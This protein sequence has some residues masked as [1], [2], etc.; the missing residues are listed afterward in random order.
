M[1]AALFRILHKEKMDRLAG[2]PGPTPRFPFGTSL[3]F[4]SKQWPWEVCAKYADEYGPMT[5]IWL[6]GR[7]AVVLNS[8]ELIGEV[9]ADQ[10]LRFYKKDPVAALRPVITPKSL[11]ISNPPQWVHARESNPLSRIDVGRWL[12]ETLATFRS[13]IA[14]RVSQLAADSRTGWID[15]Y[16]D[17]QR[18][19]FHGFAQAF[20][21]EPL[22]EQHF[23]WFQTLARTGSRRIDSLLPLTPPFNPWF[24]SA[25]KHWYR[26]FTDRVAQRRAA[27]DPLK[28]DL[29]NQILA[30]GTELSD[31]ELAEALATNFFGGVFSCSSTI[32]TSLYLAAN[33]EGARKTLVDAVRA[34]PTNCDWLTLNACRELD[35][36]LRESMRYL[37]A[38]PLY[39]RNVDQ[40][41]PVELGGHKLPPDTQLFISN[42]WLHR[43]ASHWGDPHEFRPARWLDG[44]AAENAFGPGYFFPFGRG[45]RACIGMP[46]ALYFMKV[47]LAQILATTEVLLDATRPYRPSFFFGVM[48][49][50]GLYAKFTERLRD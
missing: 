3:D 5:L 50:K 43:Q 2:I 36:F 8:P 14:D 18:L 29:L 13:V 46:F 32:N 26:D 6:G 20:W 23:Q 30:L 31:G 25:R 47:A 40:S 48:M 4:A 17:M 9:L 15:L 39:F 22:D 28:P 34:L 49:P 11:F 19:A 41:Q 27:P 42:W 33:H 37:P 10:W 35:A 7:P 16:W 45:P 24:L 44:G 38:V 1:L 21:G 12:Q